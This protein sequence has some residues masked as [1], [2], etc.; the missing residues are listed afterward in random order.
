MVDAIFID[1]GHNDNQKCIN[2][3]GRYVSRLF[4]VHDVTNRLVF[5][6]GFE[7]IYISGSKCAIA[8]KFEEPLPYKHKIKR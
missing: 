3:Y 5:P 6:N 1:A 8:Y 2:K 4:I 7:S